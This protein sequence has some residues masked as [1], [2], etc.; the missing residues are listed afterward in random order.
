MVGSQKREDHFKSLKNSRLIFFEGAAVSNQVRRAEFSLGGPPAPLQL[1]NQT[2]RC[3]IRRLDVDEFFDIEVEG[4]PRLSLFEHKINRVTKSARY[5][6]TG[7]HQSMFGFKTFIV[8]FHRLRRAL[9]HTDNFSEGIFQIGI[10][11]F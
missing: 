8:F 5:N 3:P 6:T 1:A 2:H 9:G 7:F 10:A 4:N 11:D